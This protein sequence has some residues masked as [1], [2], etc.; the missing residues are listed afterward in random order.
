[1]YSPLIINPPA[2]VGSQSHISDA[3]DEYDVTKLVAHEVYETKQPKIT[4]RHMANAEVVAYESVD[5]LLND[6]SQILQEKYLASKLDGHTVDSTYDLVE[7]LFSTEFLSHDKHQFIDVV[8]TEPVY[9]CYTSL[10]IY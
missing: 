6:V 5:R 9:K 10:I 3:E 4:G 1:M 2:I 8:D 7:L